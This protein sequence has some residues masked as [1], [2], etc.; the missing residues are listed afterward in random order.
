[1]TRT[2]ADSPGGQLDL[3][4]EWESEADEFRTHYAELEIP[5]TTAQITVIPQVIAEADLL[6]LTPRLAADRRLA[7]VV[8]QKASGA[9]H[10]YCYQVRTPGD[11]GGIGDIL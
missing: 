6:R 4:E 3:G 7:S 9:Y 2:P 11:L 5:P 1:M 8:R 10:L